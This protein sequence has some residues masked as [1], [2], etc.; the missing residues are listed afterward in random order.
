MA[1]RETSLEGRVAPTPLDDV[2]LVGQLTGFV[3]ALRGKGMPVNPSAL[4]DAGRAMSV[5]DLLDRTSLREGLAATLLTEQNHRIVFD[6][7]FD[8]WF[9]PAPGVRTTTFE[10]PHNVEGEIDVEATRDM[11]ADLLAD[12]DA[13]R[14]GRLA[15]LVA[16]IVDQ[17][18]RYES[19][20]GEA[21]SAYQAMSVVSPQTLIAKS[22]GQKVATTNDILPGTS[23]NRITV[24]GSDT[25]PIRISDRGDVYWR[26]LY[27]A[28][29]ININFI[30]DGLFFNGELLMTSGQVIASASGQ[31]VINF[32]NGGDAMDVSRDG[33]KMLVAMNMQI[34]PFNFTTQPNNALLLTL[35]L[36]PPCTADFN[37][38]GSVTVQDLFDFLAAWFAKI[39]TADF[40]NNGSITVQDL[41]DFLAA[42][43]AKC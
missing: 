43:F 7:L 23:P 42:W 19:T 22:S 33:T 21:F 40:N 20:R 32:Y 11:I 17:L 36:P 27:Y 37:G 29:T 2:P 26:G 10:L 28:P 41:F 13:E 8:L 34:P 9:P 16:Q 4:I 12:D 18:G 30:Y 31:K 38:N 5:L 15:E 24:V 35:T 39:P 1:R 14:D 3:E 6:K 25:G